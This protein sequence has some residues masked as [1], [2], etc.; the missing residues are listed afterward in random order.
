MREG[1][2]MEVVDNRL[3]DNGGI[4]EKEVKRLVY[5][6]LWCIQEKARMRPSMG[7]VVEMLEGRVVVEEPPDTQ[8]IVVDLLSIDEDAPPGDHG[9][10]RGILGNALIGHQVDS[11]EASAS[12]Y[13]FAMSALSGR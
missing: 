9:R 13:S 7:L 8:M 4:D 6:A 11:S 1:K 5:V 2:I 10:P 3:V 12:T